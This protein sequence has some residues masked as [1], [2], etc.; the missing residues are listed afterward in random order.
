MQKRNIGNDS[1]AYAL[2]MFES[3][4]IPV[5]YYSCIHMLK[6]LVSFPCAYFK[7]KSKP[8]HF[9]PLLENLHI[10]LYATLEKI[11]IATLYSSL[12]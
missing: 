2:S 12:I 7:N 9:I 4:L 8:T 10:Q 5:F 1:F 6:T 3:Y 11:N